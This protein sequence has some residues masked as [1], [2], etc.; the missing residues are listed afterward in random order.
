[1][2]RLYL[3]Y[4][5]NPW[6]R[7][8]ID[9]ANDDGYLDN[10]LSI[11]DVSAVRQR[12][13]PPQ[14]IREIVNAHTNEDSQELIEVLL[15][16]AKFPVDDIYVGFLRREES[17]IEKNP[18]TV[19]RIA[20]RLLTMPVDDVIKLCR[21]PKVD[22]R[23]M[24]E[25]F[26]NWLTSL[27]YPKLEE[28]SFAN[29]TETTDMQG[30]THSI[31]MLDG[32][33]RDFRDFVNRELGCG[34]EKELDILV[35]VKGEYIIGEAKYFSGFGGHQNDQFEDALSFL[36]NVQGEAARVAVLDGVVWLDTR[37]KMC[38]K[39][40]RLESIAMS[41]LLLPRFLEEVQVSAS[42]RT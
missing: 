26:H 33:R 31:L 23:R 39:V 20:R 38:L 12:Q 13:V 6:I 34:L 24:G 16:L 36:L 2:C 1:M 40:R 29:L 27:G 18:N 3:L 21:Q 8:S 30:K 28:D 41:A 25:L 9:L 10:L 7:E 42:Y 19:E 37:N 32:T 15:K 22:N 11:Y 17:A 4:C 14:R 35:K 5:M